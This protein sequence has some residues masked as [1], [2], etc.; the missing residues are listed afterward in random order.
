MA[1]IIKPSLA[2]GEIAPDLY[3]RVDVA[4]YQ[5][6]AKKL[7]NF[8]VHPYGGISNRPGTEFVGEVRDSTKVHRV[9]P[10]SFSTVQTYALEFGNLTLRIVKDGGHVLESAK[11]ITGITK[12]NPGVV[13]SVAHGLSNGDHVYIASVVGMTEV[14]GRTFKIAN[15]ATDTFELQDLGGTNLSTSTYTTY[16]SGGTASRV[17]TVTT[18]YLEADLPLLKFVQSAD[19]MTITHPDYA[20]RDLTRTGD[21]AW[22]L[23]EVSFV[24]GVDRPVGMTITHSSAGSTTYR[25][26]VTAVD[27][28]TGEIGLRGVNN[29]VRTITGITSAAPA[30]V[31]A[32]AHGFAN[33]DEVYIYNVT[34]MTDAN[35]KP[36]TAAGVTSS[37]FELA[38]TDFTGYAAYVS[39]GSV[40]RTFVI[41]SSAP[42]LTSST[43]IDLAWTAVS[44][45]SEYNVYREKSGTY[46]FIG[47]ATGTTFRD[48]NINPDMSDGPPGYRNPF[49]G[50]DNRPGCVTYH[51]ERKVYA[52][53][54]ERPQTIFESRAGAYDNFTESN[55]T[56]DDDAVTYTIV[57]RQVNEVRHVLSMG[58]LVIL[59]SG[60]EWVA[61][62]GGQSD[63]ITPTSLVVKAQSY[64]GSSHV[65]PLVVG[66]IVLFVQDGGMVIRELGYRYDVDKYTGN[67]LTVL[68]PHLFAER[69]VKEW[70]FAQSPFC[71]AHI[72]MSDGSLIGLTY[73]K[74]QDVWAFWRCETDGDVES[75][76][77]IREGDEDAT[78][79]VIR[80][81]IGSR[82]CRYIER[83]HSRAFEDVRDAFFVDCGV[84][85]DSP[86]T[87]TG[88]TSA[89]PP[90]VTTLTNHG[91]S[92]GDLIDI[93]DTKR[94]NPDYHLGQGEI[95]TESPAT[96]RNERLVSHATHGQRYKAAGVTATTFELTD[97]IEGTDIDGTAWD[98][99]YSGGYAREAVTTVTGLWH[100]EGQT[101]SVLNTGDVEAQKT[102]TNG[103]ITLDR[104]GSLV[105]VGL[106]YVADFES[107]SIDAGDGSLQGKRKTVPFVTLRVVKTRGGFVGPSLKDGDLKEIKQRQYEDYNEPTRLAQG[108]L[109]LQMTPQWGTGGNVCYRQ[110]DPLP[111][112]IIALIPEIQVGGH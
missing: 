50:A 60:G 11:V 54:D 18:P 8:F 66:D 105:H 63:T 13:T 37:T 17:Y 59:T 108:D 65:P 96:D 77:S 64:R 111:V 85:L 90:V 62:P 6:A 5:V 86:L 47:V 51:E 16:V 29:T 83:L 100:L 26:A 35:G 112:T 21:A 110:S 56:Q 81:K 52:R 32:S 95:A 39:A 1:S 61:R 89:E 3:G 20:P 34:G 99:W 33:G 70:A 42:A 15:V 109:R 101:V 102:V 107:L 84:S 92:N 57:S 12:A 79:F 73:L 2:G 91:F 49:D 10:F 67:D 7:V 41:T 55:P 58:D 98:A 78:Y 82:F 48:D 38:N 53:T 75:V 25:Y 30:V 36:Y 74:E 94:R 44:G 76:C 28:E 87:I 4:K 80:R 106:P 45:I 27:P 93:L 103:S 19:V 46:G 23:T 31:T 22:T 72:V 14:N 24:P 71:L 88:I 68:A 97:Y 69:T 40:A 9:I 104:E 43:P